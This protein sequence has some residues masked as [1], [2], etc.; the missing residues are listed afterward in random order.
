MA[1]LSSDELEIV[2]AAYGPS[3]YLS[4]TLDSTAA[5]M[6]ADIRI[7]VLD[8][9]S[10]DDAVERIAAAHAGRVAYRRNDQNLGTSGSFN[11]AMRIS[12]ARYTLLVGPDDLLLPGAADAYAAA[13]TRY[14]GVAAVQPA[15]VTIDGDGR[16]SA[17]L[18]DRI[19]RLLQPKPGI[20]LDEQLATGLLLGNWTYNPAIAWRTDLVGT[21]PFDE[22]LHTAMDLDRLLRLAF[23]GEA[24]GLGDEAAFAYRRHSGAVSSVNKGRKRLAE[25]LGIHAWARTEARARG[26]RKAAVAAQGAASA[27]L[28]GL[29][30][31]ATA[32]GASRAERMA[33]LGL[34]VRPVAADPSVTPS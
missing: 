24:F 7:T 14:R 5:A 13:L 8:D 18:A 1:S 12:R 22:E 15:V 29:Q 33:T 3:P 2:V 25:E 10:P 21:I 4:L 20:L 6:P 32:L 28:H 9:A 26:W 30:L 34:A 23:A 31:A 19:K 11:A 27:R 17:A 16:P